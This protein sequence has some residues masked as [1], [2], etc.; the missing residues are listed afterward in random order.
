MANDSLQI[1]QSEPAPGVLL[2]AMSGAILLGPDS[3]RIESMVRSAIERG[4][5][6]IVFDLTAVKKIDST[7]IGRFISAF[8]MLAKA[9][10]EMRMITGPGLVRKSFQATRLETVFR[11]V[12]SLTEALESLAK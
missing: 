12:P 4:K 5:R 8:H 6:A 7:G 1:E 3:E 2:L 10:G 9:H 11:V